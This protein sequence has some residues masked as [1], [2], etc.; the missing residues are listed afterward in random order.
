MPNSQTCPFET[1][2]THLGPVQSACLQATGYKY[3]RK[4][5]E[6]LYLFCL[7]ASTR[8]VTESGRINTSEVPGTE[9]GWLRKQYSFLV[10]SF[11]SDVWFSQSVQKLLASQ[12]HSSRWAGGIG[13]RNV[14]DYSD[15]IQKTVSETARQ[16]GRGG[17]RP[18]QQP[19]WRQ[20]QGTPGKD[21]P[22]L[23]REAC[24][25]FS[26]LQESARS[27]LRRWVGI[28]TCQPA[29]NQR[30]GMGNQG[31]PFEFQSPQLSLC[32][33]TGP[34]ANKGGSW[35][36]GPVGRVQQSR[37]SVS[38][39]FTEMRVSAVNLW[40]PHAYTHASSLCWCITVITTLSHTV[41]LK[42]SL[43]DMSR[44]QK[45]KI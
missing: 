16:S 11:E 44:E 29:H 23:C 1:K 28:E 27:L 37:V 6:T 13:Q 2:D 5:V 33:V 20:P 43:P 39:L 21:S 40:F 8:P 25:F 26:S 31:N 4:T 22:F 15:A 18:S 14:V 42:T 45:E 10:G 12:H 35:E 19:L 17:A 7:P 34:W 3:L 38:S 24:D 36:L 32:V 30:G 41:Q 9:Q